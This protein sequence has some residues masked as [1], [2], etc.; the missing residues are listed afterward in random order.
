MTGGRPASQ[1]LQGHVGQNGE[2]HGL[3]RIGRDANVVGS[4][5]WHWLEQCDDPFH[6]HRVLHASAGHDDLL[7]GTPDLGALPEPQ[8]MVR[9]INSMR[10]DIKSASWPP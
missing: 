1:P 8:A 2:N 9:A 4:E 10:V 3:A 7:H 6:E 5:N